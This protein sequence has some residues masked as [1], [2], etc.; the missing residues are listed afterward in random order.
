MALKILWTCDIDS[1]HLWVI[2]VMINVTLYEAWH[3]H[4]LC[5]GGRV[6]NKEHK[7]W[8][9]KHKTRSYTKQHVKESLTV[10]T[11]KP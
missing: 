1:I 5:M 10:Q 9:D 4:C 7:N 3:T 11:H 6:E 2:T 8:N